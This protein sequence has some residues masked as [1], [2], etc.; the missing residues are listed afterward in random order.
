MAHAALVDAII[1]NDVEQVEALLAAGADAN[2]IMSTADAEKR[3]LLHFA[4]VRGYHEV[5][6]VLVK[7]GS[8]VDATDKGGKTPLHWAAFH[9]H[10]EVA[11]VLVEA[12]CKVD[13]TDKQGQTPLHCAAGV[14]AI[15]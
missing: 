4:A 13:A 9:G 10:P 12:G 8:K 1:K 7:A 3:T 6:R 11:R 5:A 2:A 15:T 14:K